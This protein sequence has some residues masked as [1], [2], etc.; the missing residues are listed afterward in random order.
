MNV[1]PESDWLKLGIA[2]RLL[3]DKRTLS[4]D[5]LVSIGTLQEPGSSADGKAANAREKAADKT[6]DVASAWSVIRPESG[7]IFAR[8]S[9]P[10]NASVTVTCLAEDSARL[11]LTLRRLSPAD[12][13]RVRDAALSKKRL[14]LGDR[15]IEIATVA[16]AGDGE[17]GLSATLDARDLKALQTTGPSMSFAVLDRS[18]NPATQSIEVDATGAGKAVSELMASCGKA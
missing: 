2:T 14:R 11:D 8:F 10:A 17:Q 1:V 12:L 3:P 18:G 15:E 5:E 13:V 9:D 7:S 16:A 6:A 4:I